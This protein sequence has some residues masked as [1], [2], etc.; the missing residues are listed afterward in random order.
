MAIHGSVNFTDLA[1]TSAGILVINDDKRLVQPL[2]EDVAQVLDPTYFRP[3]E[4]VGGG[5]GWPM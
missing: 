1:M 5:E 2:L 4:E 3:V